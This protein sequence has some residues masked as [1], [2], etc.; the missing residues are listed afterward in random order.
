MNSNLGMFAVLAFSVIMLLIPSSSS[1]VNAQ[2]Y[3]TYYEQDQYYDGI[4]QDDNYKKSNYENDS[5]NNKQDDKKTD[6]PVIIIKNEPLQ[7]KEKKEKKKELPMILVKKD[8]LYCDTFAGGSGVSCFSFVDGTIAG[9]DSGRYVEECTANTGPEG[10]VCDNINE[11]F[12]EIIVTDDID[13]PGSEDGTKLNFNG[14]R[15]SITE[16]QII[17]TM[18]EGGEQDLFCQKT[19]FDDGF[20]ISLGSPDFTFVPTCVDFEGDCSGIVS[21]G[22]LKECTVKNYILAAVQS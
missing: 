6:E 11:S 22:E 12:F 2:E 5:Y 9:K 19:G 13:F 10:E 16:E 18:N 7:K 21:D 15:F 14:E 4:Y 1:L 17:E 3:D 20:G 8:V